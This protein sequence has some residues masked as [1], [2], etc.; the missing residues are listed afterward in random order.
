MNYFFM[1]LIKQNNNIFI[2]VFI[3]L[4]YLF[5][6]NKKEKKEK[7]FKHQNIKSVHGIR[8]D[9]VSDLLLIIIIFNF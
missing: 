6:S 8:F 3:Y 1:S 5:A 7:K 4:F 2:N 9:F